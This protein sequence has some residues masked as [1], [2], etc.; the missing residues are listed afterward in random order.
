MI[1][2][3]AEKCCWV[4]A[5]ESRGCKAEAHTC[6]AMSAG[7]HEATGAAEQVLHCLQGESILP[8]CSAHIALFAP[9]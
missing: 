1:V 5:A 8:L 3:L 4:Q 7:C 6:L 2:C 9:L